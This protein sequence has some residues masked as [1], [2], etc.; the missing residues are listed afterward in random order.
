MVNFNVY[1]YRFS[2]TGV[3]KAVGDLAQDFAF[4][5]ADSA[6]GPTIELF[7]ANP[8]LTNLPARNLHGIGGVPR[9][10]MRAF[11][12]RADTN[13]LRNSWRPEFTSA[14]EQTDVALRR[15]RQSFEMGQ[16]SQIDSRGP[17]RTGPPCS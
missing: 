5:T 4:F 17:G 9:S 3:E 15:S 6:D 2:V 10:V 11:D 1:G 8:P 13:C 16:E 12:G 14:L 7:Q